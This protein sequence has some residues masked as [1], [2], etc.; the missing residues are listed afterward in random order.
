M[1]LAAL[2]LGAV[3][4]ADD[5]EFALKPSVTPDTALATSD[6][7]KPWNLPMLAGRAGVACEFPGVHVE[8]DADGGREGPAPG[9]PWAPSPRPPSWTVTVHALRH[10]NRF[11]SEYET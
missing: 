10:R 1:D 9:C 6:R 5:V 3:A 11:L 7:A 2:H 4:D 8:L